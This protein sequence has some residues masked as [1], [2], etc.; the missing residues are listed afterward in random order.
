MKKR[1]RLKMHMPNEAAPKSRILG[2][3]SGKI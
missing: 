2:A 3:A 1:V